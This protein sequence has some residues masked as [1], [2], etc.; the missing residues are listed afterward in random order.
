MSKKETPK[1]NI[2]IEELS[3]DEKNRLVDVFVWLLRQDKKQNPD[4][5]K[6]KERKND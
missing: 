3:L 5:Y 1:Q 6:Y 2:K 4:N